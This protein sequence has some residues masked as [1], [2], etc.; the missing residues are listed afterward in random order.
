LDSE[1]QAIRRIQKNGSRADADALVRRYYDEI[2]VYVWR[3][4]SDRDMALDLTQEIFMAAL[5]AI[6][7][8]NPRRAGFRTW[9]YRI[10][11]NKLT[12]A[13]RSRAAR[14]EWVLAP[15]EQADIEDP[16]SFVRQ[17]E[18]RELISKLQARVNDMDM[19]SQRIFRLKC[20][21]EHT[22][23]QIAAMLDMPEATVKTRY[24]RL[25]NILRE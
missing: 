19:D 5:R 6:H 24:Y 10:A 13:F 20:F 23:A 22:F 1:A 8:Y 9:L 3:Q 16:Q 14:R 2:F 4:A 12:D 17:I 15:D 7:L 25:I 18:S 11:T 21:G